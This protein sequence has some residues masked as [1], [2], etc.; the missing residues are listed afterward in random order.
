MITEHRVHLGDA[1]ELDLLGDGSIDLV[2]TSPPYPMIEMWDGIFGALSARAAEAL[3]REDGPAAFEAMHQ[4]LDR[5]WAGLWRVL[6]PGGIAAINIGD[7]TRT[8][9]GQFAL[10]SNHARILTGATKLGFTVLPDILW[11][12]PT[13]AP[14]KFMGS[15]MLPA[16]AYVTY[17]HEYI[18]ILRR[19][20]KRSFASAADKAHRQ[21]SA[22]F[23]EE[24]NTWF[25]DL[26]E[27]LPGTRQGLKA[28]RERSA[29]FPFELAHRL[30]LMYSVQ[31]D[32][33]LDPF[34]GTGTTL[35]AAM[36]TGRQGLGVERDESLLPAVKAQVAD[37]VALGND[38]I[39]A[40]L[41]AHTAFVNARQAAGKA[42]GHH[43]AFYDMP[44]MTGQ[45]REIVFPRPTALEA[46]E[47]HTWKLRLEDQ[48]LRALF[49]R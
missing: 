48:R 1:R 12:K 41:A 19:G 11:R 26:W 5:V 10:Y 21:R 45:E 38:A 3:G 22:Y 16:G 4:E 2:V 44:V 20:D 7:A 32:R 15:G 8:L 47:N 31:G 23:W 37:V 39:D 17:E 24:R 27:G 35:A 25:S 42:I 33:V 30:I 40:R 6:R 34:L 14:N 49:G 9:G 18:L 46:S 36:A 43:N 29:A 13:N 28:D